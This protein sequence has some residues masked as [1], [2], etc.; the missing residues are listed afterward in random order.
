MRLANFFEE[1]F[2]AGN[3]GISVREPW[4]YCYAPVRTKLLYRHVVIFA[5]ER[6]AGVVAGS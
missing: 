5:R 1:V 2:E 3:R 4:N 6:V